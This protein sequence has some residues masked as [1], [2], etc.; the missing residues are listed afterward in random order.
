MKLLLL[1]FL[2]L[3]ANLWDLSQAGLLSSFFAAD[4][5]AD[6]AQ[7]L[8]NYISQYPRIMSTTGNEVAEGQ[9]QDAIDACKATDGA[10]MNLYLNAV[11]DCSKKCDCSYD[12]VEG[13]T[14]LTLASKNKIVMMK[15][16]LQAGA[17]PSTKDSHEST[18]LITALDSMKFPDGSKYGSRLSPAEKATA[19]EKNQ[20]RAEIVALLL[21]AKADT[22]GTNMIG[23]TALMYAS[24][25]GHLAAVK[26]L[27]KA[28]S[29][30][31]YQ[32]PSHFDQEGWTALNRAEMNNDKEVIAALRKEF[33]KWEKKNKAA[34]ATAAEDVKAAAKDAKA[35]AAAG[36]ALVA[37][38]KSGDKKKV[39]E[40]LQKGADINYQN[41]KG[42]TCLHF[43]AHGAHKD[44]VQILLSAGADLTLRTTGSKGKTAR[45]LALSQFQFNGKNPVHKEIAGIIKAQQEKAEL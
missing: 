42:T 8:F 13:K 5:T 32:A 39:D 19:I 29:N 34:A 16:L 38:C 25:H 43:A 22:D 21:A 45:A 14:L 10:D 2:T 41:E 1:P 11:C 30:P 28:G 36:S 18:P 33:P 40:L 44:I 12:N 3:F 6:G 26:S 23:A 4:C 37:A 24:M 17:N 35:A 31:L 15:V 9:L 20:E 27:L 7:Y